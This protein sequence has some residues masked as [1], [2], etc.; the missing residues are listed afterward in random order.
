MQRAR[1]VLA[2]P[3]AQL[4][5]HGPGR[6]IGDPQLPLQKLGRDAALVATHQI[7]GEKPLAQTG[8]RAMQHGSGGDQ[9]LPVAGGAFVDPGPRLQPPSLPPAAPGTGKPAGPA[10]PRQV[11]NAPLLHPKSRDKFQQP[12]HPIPHDRPALCYSKAR[13]DTRIFSEPVLPGQGDGVDQIAGLIATVHRTLSGLG[14]NAPAPLAEALTP[15]VPI[16]RSVQPDHVVCL[17]CG[18]RGQML[19]RHLSVAHG[20]EPAT[21]RGRWKLAT[22]HPLTALAYSAKRSAVAKELGL[23]RRP[24]PVETPPAPPRRGRPRQGPETA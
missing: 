6:L 21:Y 23:G 22:D 4:V 19:R 2:Q 13:P 5:R 18:Y 3:V 20:L 16:R 10:K 7:G 12:S 8:A 14:T 11:L 9:F 24:A 1:R 17:E 15:A